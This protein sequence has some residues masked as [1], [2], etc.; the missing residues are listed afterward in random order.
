MFKGRID[1]LNLRAFSPMLASYVKILTTLPEDIA[2]GDYPIETGG[3]YAV[4]SPTMKA[5]GEARVETHRKYIDIQYILSGEERIGYTDASN[6]TP[7]TD[8]SVEHDIT[9][10]K[11]AVDWMVYKEGDFGIFFPEDGHAPDVYTEQG[12]PCRKVVVKIPVDVL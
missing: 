6:L 5:E 9:F 3:R 2:D 12:I 4:F 11:G 10:H 7:L 1:S 8:Y